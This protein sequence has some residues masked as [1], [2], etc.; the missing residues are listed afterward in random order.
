MDMK[1]F[2]LLFTELSMKHE[3]S[4]HNIDMCIFTRKSVTQYAI[5]SRRRLNDRTSLSKFNQN[6]I[7]DRRPNFPYNMKHLEIIKR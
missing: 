5:D 6:S 2:Y 3:R 4:F 7:R 1:T